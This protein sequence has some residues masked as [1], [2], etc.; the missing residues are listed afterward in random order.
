MKQQKAQIS[1]LELAEA[2]ELFFMDDRLI[3]LRSIRPNSHKRR[4][5]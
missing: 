5:F 4:C 3:P 2:F 1:R